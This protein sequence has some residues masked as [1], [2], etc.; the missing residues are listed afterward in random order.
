MQTTKPFGGRWRLLVCAGIASGL[1][2]GC[3]VVEPSFEK[4][5]QIMI[6]KTVDELELAQAVSE[7]VPKGG[8]VA[9]VSVEKRG[10]PD[11]PIIATIEDQLIQ[12]LLANGLV[13]VERDDDLVEKLVEE[14]SGDTYRLVYLPSDIKISSAEATGAL[15]SRSTGLSAWL[16]GGYGITEITGVRPDTLLI[17]DTQLR[18]ADYLVSYRVLECGII[19]RKGAIGMKK[20]ESMV[21]LH[22]RVQDTHTGD[23]LL[24]ENLTAT[25]ED[26][27]KSSEVGDLANYHYSLYTND[28]PLETGAQRGRREIQAQGGKAQSSVRQGLMILGLLVAMMLTFQVAA[29]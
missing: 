25:R 5:N 18:P 2:T 24:A 7:V 13:V 16:G 27:V 28:L 8:A 1:L 15:A 22:M 10:T 19:Y 11:H 29:D 9:L 12:S 6:E 3:A 26:E 14:R 4:S 23:V 20:R 17:V 21:R